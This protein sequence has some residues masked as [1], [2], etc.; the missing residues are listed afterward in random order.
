MLRLGVLTGGAATSARR[1]T[2]RRLLVPVLAALTAVTLASPANAVP[3]DP[4]PP[5][6]VGPTT[7]GPLEVSELTTT[8]V[9]L[10]WAASVDDVGVVGY[11]VYEAFEDTLRTRVTATNSITITGLMRARTYRFSVSAYDLVG[12][13][14]RA[15]STLQVTM[16]PGDHAPPTAP[17]APV[18]SRIL[19]TSLALTWQR[20]TDDGY[21]ESYRVF[22]VEAGRLF[23]VIHGPLMWA[24]R[25]RATSMVT[26]LMPNTTYTFVVQAEDETGKVSPLSP[27]VT[28]TT[29]RA[30]PICLV[31]YDITNQWPGGFRATV[32]ISNTSPHTFSPWR[33][34][35][36]FRNGQTV[37]Q[38]WNGVLERQEAG[39]V[40]VGNPTWDATLAP[41]DSV[42]F[43][44]VGTRDAANEVPYV[45]TLNGIRCGE[46]PMPPPN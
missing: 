1:R 11:R 18:A 12:N 25:D 33:L 39:S 2:A 13:L 5:D 44:F 15:T 46:P 40:T 22:R 42:H 31:D 26:H 16:E 28:V 38:L 30:A 34:S 3:P 23:P 32:R 10:R 41:G 43:G 8:S 7:P 35:W 17:G 19:A 29:A 14:S 45:F 27:A 6:A 9:T 36:S 37:R 4:S 20:S 24:E 21:V